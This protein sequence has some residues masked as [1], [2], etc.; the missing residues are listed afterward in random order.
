M[1]YEN[2]KAAESY[3]RQLKRDNPQNT[4]RLDCFTSG[5]KIVWDVIQTNRFC[6]KES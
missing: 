6:S 5:N 2:R 1:T 4:F 3:R